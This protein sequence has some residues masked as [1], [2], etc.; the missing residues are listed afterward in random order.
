MSSAN[1]KTPS[2]RRTQPGPSNAGSLE[3]RCSF[4]PY[5]ALDNRRLN[6][7]IGMMHKAEREPGRTLSRAASLS[8]TP[9]K[10]VCPVCSYGVANPTGLKHHM[11]ARHGSG[12]RP[13]SQ[14]LL[15][16]APSAQFLSPPGLG[17]AVDGDPPEAGS[18]GDENRDA[19]AARSERRNAPGEDYARLVLWKRRFQV[20][21]HVPHAARLQAARKY[22]HL[23]D[24]VVRDNDS[25]SW[26]NLLEFPYRA[27]HITTAAGVKP[28]AT[29]VKEN[30]S[31]Y[32]RPLAPAAH[33]R[34]I[35]KADLTDARRGK[36]AESRLTSRGDLVGAIRLLSSSESLVS[37]EDAGTQREMLSKHPAPC[38][39]DVAPLL[40][41]VRLPRHCSADEVMKAIKSFPPASSGG[42]DGLTAQHLLD[43][44][45]VGGEVRRLLLGS[46][47]RVCDLI[48]RG[49]VAEDARNLVFGSWLVAA[50]KPG[51]GL[52]P[53]AIGGTLRRLTAK[54]LLLRIRGAAAAYLNPRQLGFATKGGC[55]IAIHSARTY[56]AEGK[57][58][59]M[60]K[61]DFK[62]AFNSHRRDT[63]LKEVHRLFPEIYPMVAQTYLQPLPISFGDT[64]IES[65]T[66]CQQGDVFSPLLFC[67]VVHRTLESLQSEVAIGYL[68]D[69]TLLS[70]DPRVI[71]ED[72][73]RIQEG[74]ALHGLDIQPAKCEVFVQGFP[75]AEKE[76]I[77]ELVADALPGCRLIGYPKDLKLLGSPIFEAGVSKALQ[78]KSEAY[79]LTFQRLTHVG[80]HAATYLLQKSA[81]V[82]RLTYLLRTAPTF[83]AK[84]DLARL[85]EQ[86][87]KAFESILKISV[88]GAALEQVSLPVS[89]GGMGI[90]TPS[91]I[92]LA[93]F[94]SSCCAAVEDVRHILG[95]PDREVCFAAEATAEFVEQFGS[96]PPTDD[97]PSQ[98]KWT[99]LACE[100]TLSS[101]CLRLSQSERDTV[102]L[103]HVSLPESG[104]WLQALPSQNVGTALTDADFILAAGLRLGLPLVE[105]GAVCVCGVPVDGLGL[106]RLSCNKLASGRLARHHAVNDLLSRALRQA[107]VANSKEPSNLSENAGLRPDGI[108]HRP[109]SRGK[110]MI[111]DVSIRDAFAD[112]YRSIARTAKAVAA[113]GEQDKRTKYAPLTEEYCLVPFVIDTAGVWGE[114]ALRLVKELGKRIAA[115]NGDTRAASFIRQR[116]SIE[117]QRGNARMLTGGIPHENA[118]RELDVLV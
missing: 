60:V 101:L 79:E 23:L 49:Q 51:G 88:H 48:A 27:L 89:R 50:S 29:C 86:F 96:V 46:L 71:A 58:A 82:P 74:K 80:S 70:P 67:L 3:L 103:A 93:A 10:L 84:P 65:R 90:P 68:D 85:D 97:Q 25:Q 57:D 100:S 116:I 81:G 77:S 106:H 33:K 18:P 43:L 38:S 75:V 15:S 37:S 94:A 61:I 115:K 62:N 16:S 6:I 2:Q 1:D 8:Q 53:I 110:R 31:A 78:E 41:G 91:S 11:R 69:F 73:Q 9:S 36:T 28:L 12:A 105:E 47:S 95:D 35:R 118:L 32:E 30:L 45:A 76:R 66:G 22:I 40:P 34:R 5:I 21:P 83:R 59:V 19:S 39:D 114:D 107:G 17:P 55:E 14:P 56:L 7:H 13:Y 87:A 26:L 92:A 102:R 112:C 44:L 24:S 52:R 54:I 20:Q 108:T 42:C 98:L 63:M 72:I 109:W 104:W 111:W 99:A 4:C 113:R 64:V 117:V